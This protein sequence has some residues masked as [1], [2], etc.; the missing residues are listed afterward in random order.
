VVAGSSVDDSAGGDGDGNAEPL[1]QIEFVVEIENLGT[2]SA[3]AITGTLLT[4]DPDVTI[5]DDSA[6]F[7]TIGSGQTGDNAASPFLITVDAYPTDELVELELY[8]STGTRYDTYDVVTLVLDLSQT[9]VDDGDSPLVFALRQNNPNPFT[10]GTTLAFELP[11][12]SHATLSVYN[13]AG[14]K[15]ATVVDSDYPAGRHSAVWN[16]QGDDGRD[17]SAGI[18]FYMLEAAQGRSARKL[19]KLK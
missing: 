17:V 19:I 3:G 15:V 7:G 2:S 13:V 16:G 18:Y 14:R 11:G 4:S 8:L 10:A 1:E 6:S 12:P 5:D 9:G